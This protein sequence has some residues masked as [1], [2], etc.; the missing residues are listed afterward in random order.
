MLEMI[1]SVEATKGAADGGD[2]TTSG[3]ADG[4]GDATDDATDKPGTAGTG[5][6]PPG[7]MTESSSPSLSSSMESLTRYVSVLLLSGSFSLSPGTAGRTG[8]LFV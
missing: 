7:R 5:L 3:D 1:D 6:N 2:D 4:D 8:N